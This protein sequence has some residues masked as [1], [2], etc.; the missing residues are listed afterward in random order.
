MFQDGPAPTDYANRADAVPSQ[1]TSMPPPPTPTP[2]RHSGAPSKPHDNGVA[3]DQSSFCFVDQN[4][5]GGFFNAHKLPPPPKH[6]QSGAPSK[7][8]GNGVAAVV[9][10]PGFVDQDVTGDFFNAHHLQ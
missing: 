9:G 3:A 10:S 2:Q 6:Q 7:S 1:M 4:A 5:T 8:H